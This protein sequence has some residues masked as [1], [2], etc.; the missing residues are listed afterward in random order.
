M[1]RV[2]IT[3]A[4]LDGINVDLL[5]ETCLQSMRPLDGFDG[6]FMNDEQGETF[7]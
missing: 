4:P 2:G 3:L 5:L 7:A 1:V 6:A